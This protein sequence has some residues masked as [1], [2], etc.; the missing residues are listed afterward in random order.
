MKTCIRMPKSLWLV[1]LFLSLG[2]GVVMG[3]EGLVA[4]YSFDEGSGPIVRDATGQSGDGKIHG[5]KFVKMQDGFALEFDGIDDYVE[6]PDSKNLQLDRVTLEAWV[7]S[8]KNTGGSVASKNGCSSYRQNYAIKLGPNVVN[9]RLVKCPRIGMYSQTLGIDKNKWYHLVGTYDGNDIRIYINGVPK[10]TNDTG[11]FAVGT[12]DEPLYIGAS[13]YG[14]KLGSFFEGR[15]DDVRIYNRALTAQEIASRYQADKDSRVS[16]LSRILKQVSRFEIKDTTPAMVCLATPPPDSTVGAGASLSARFSDQGSGIDVASA[17]ILLDGKDV[18]KQ[19]KVETHSVTLSPKQPLAKGIHRVEVSV[20]DQAGNRSNRLKWLFGVDIPVPVEVKF[21]KGVFLVN[22]EPYFPLGIYGA[23]SVPSKQFPFLLHPTIPGANYNP[24]LE[25]AAAAGINCMLAGE[26]AT[27]LDMLLAHRLKVMRHLHHASKSLVKGNRA[28]LD[29][30]L[31]GKDHPALLLWWNEYAGESEKDIGTKVYEIVKEK[32]R[33]HP[34]VYMFQWGGRIS[35]AYYVYSY[36]IL[37]PLLPD[38]SLAGVSSLIRDAF[39][40]AKAEGKGKQV[41]YISQ[42]FDY[43]IADSGGGKP[44]ALEG[45]FRPSREELRAINYLA[46]AEGVKGLLFYATSPPIGDTGYS[47]NVTIYPRQWTELLKTSS[48][49]RYLSPVLAAGKPAN[50]VRLTKA[51]PAIHYR[52]LVYNG[53][54]TLIAVNVERKLAL[55]NWSFD[56][57]VKPAVLFEDRLLPKKVKAMADMFKPLEVH[58]Y[59]WRE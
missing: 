48:E 13:F 35:D 25:Q 53:E 58:I 28:H 30:L 34:V 49:I 23:H 59:R 1:G 19:A 7:N 43:R 29:R 56:T 51:N 41:W 52:E 8:K 3:R 15:I 5:A 42:A 37:N 12:T 31:T 38:S 55:A 9:F 16:E 45:G 47:D 4:H 36:P 21:D 22:N 24:Y 57:P 11:E 54:H 27:T 46:L 39:D 2:S 20:S 33:R 40:T 14:V 26:S 10:N 17:K 6:V 44:V 18:T 50:T 32:D